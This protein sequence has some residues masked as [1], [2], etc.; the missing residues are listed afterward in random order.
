[1]SHATESTDEQLA[2]AAQGGDA[3]AFDRLARRYLRR[4][5]ALAWQSTRSVADAEDAVQEAFHR[6][7]RALPDYDAARPFEPWFFTILRNVV[8]SMQ[9]KRRR[10]AALVPTDSLAD[11]R[12]AETAAEPACRDA[13]TTTALEGAI[14]ALAPM[15]QTCLRLCEIEGFTSAEAGHMLG[16]AEG[17]VRT[18]LYRGRDGIKRALQVAPEA[19]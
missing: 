11:E 8:R 13:A 10:R 1:M 14:D 18:H 19:G 12:L 16:I 9:S 7:V 6:A 17:T 3:D 2:R 15:Q 4:G 5:M